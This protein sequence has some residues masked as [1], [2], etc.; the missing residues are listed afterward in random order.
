MKLLRPDYENS[1]LNVSNSLLK[2]YNV[3]PF[4][5]THPVLD[6]VL[7][8]KY[9]HIIYILLDGMG[10][11]IVSKLDDDKVLKKYT[12]QPITSVFPPT[13]VAAT[14]SV[15]SARTP[16]ETG[17]LGWVQYFKQVDSDVTVFLNRDFYT[18]ETYDVVVRNEYLQYKNILELAKEKNPD[19]HTNIFFPNFI[20]EFGTSDSFKDEVDQVLLVTHNTDRSFNY[21]Y[22]TEPDLTE[23]QFGIDSKE[24]KETL[25]KLN[26]D[27]ESLINNISD[28]TLV[29]CIADHGLTN[30]E[31]INIFNY[32]KLINMLERKPSIEPRAINFFVKPEYKK[33]F[34]DEFNKHFEDKYNLFTKE[35]ILE[36]K[37]FGDGTPHQL[38]DMF[39]GDYIAIAV[40]KYM[41]SIND[42]KSYK[43]HHAGLTSDEMLVPLIIYNK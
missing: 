24:V 18:N 9:N 7:E 40:D 26:N 4:H 11:N 12:V 39:I 42:N 15:L 31:E 5:Q 27:V 16:I 23:H 2:Y 22:W 37:I 28:D 25:L 3:T 20:K 30:V 34:K 43:G 14:N 35:S 17:Y 21:L 10:H 41:F 19:L 6:K 38:T 13:T 32:D 8:N 1:I 29:I 33:S 36:S